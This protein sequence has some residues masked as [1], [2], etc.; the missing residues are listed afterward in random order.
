MTN[1]RNIGLARSDLSVFLNSVGVPNATALR[2]RPIV[3]RLFRSGLAVLAG[4]PYRGERSCLVFE[5]SNNSI[6][7]YFHREGIY[8]MV[9]IK[10][11]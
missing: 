8:K 7:F 1:E 6:A 11:N 10:W 9:V 2:D 4:K 5:R 3:D